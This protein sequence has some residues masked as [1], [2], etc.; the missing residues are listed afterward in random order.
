[1]KLPTRQ[2]TL[3]Q[4]DFFIYAAADSVYFD[5]HARPLINSVLKNMPELGI[6]IHIYDPTPDQIAF[7]QQPGVSCTYEHLNPVDFNK[8]TDRWLRR[9][10]FD[11]DRQRQMFKKGQTLGAQ[12]LNKLVKQTYYAC[13]RF[14]RLAEILPQGQ[15]CLALDVDGL[16]R[17]K[18]DYNLGTADFYLYEKP[19]DGTHLAG[20]ILFNGQAGTQDF[21]QNYADHL[22]SAINQD[23]VY[24]FL[25]QL[26]LDRLVPRY[27]KGLLPMSYI[28]WAMRPDSA[29]WSAKGKRKELDIFKQEQQRYA[30]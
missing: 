11:N 19:K 14:I 20:A 29:I 26:I 2:E 6:H 18:F 17:G 12:E 8:I 23:D 24:W 1:M 22:T 16:V 15:R 28:D 9:T 13:V 7:C 10:D 5:I 3:N 4:K 27:N 21:L 25:D 30:Q